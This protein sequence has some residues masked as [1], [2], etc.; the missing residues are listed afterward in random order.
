M[1]GRILATSLLLCC[2]AAMATEDWS[3]SRKVD[4]VPVEFRPTESGFHVHRAEVS[5]C[6]DLATLESFVADTS[7]FPEWIPFTRS[8]RLLDDSEGAYVY[9]V[10]STT[11]WPAKDRD[12]IYRI[13]REAASENSI[14]LVMTGL[15]DYQPPE[16]TAERIRTAEGA[17]HL[18]LVEDHTRVSYELYVDPG[19]VPA[20]LANR[21]LAT[22]VGRTLANLSAEFPCP[23]T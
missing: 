6:A 9:Y 11:P 3:P 18:T 15:P 4:G 2:A 10:R 20:F 23:S 16:E 8:A 1:S 13:T 19:S 12:M 22:V 21:R 17:W 5:V 14:R 7:R